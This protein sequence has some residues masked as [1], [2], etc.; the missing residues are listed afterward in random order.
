MGEFTDGGGNV[1]GLIFINHQALTKA[2]GEKP[3]ITDADLLKIAQF[4]KLTALHLEAQP[5]SDAGIQVLKGVPHLKQVGFHYMAKAN[6]ASASPDFIEVIDGMR[7]L[8]VIEI[9][10]NQPR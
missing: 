7:D 1:T 4:P 9:K 5:I 3:G 2:V 10:H 6:G 8:E